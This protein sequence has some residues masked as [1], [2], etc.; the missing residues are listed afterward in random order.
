M[1]VLPF[2]EDTK[3]KE[4]AVLEELLRTWTHDHTV[5]AILRVILPTLAKLCERLFQDHLP[6]GRY[7]DVTSDVKKI[8]VGMPKHNKFSESVFG[9]LDQ[10]TR[11][12]PNITT[13]SAE[14]CDVFQQQDTGL[15]REKRCRKSE[16][17][18]ERSQP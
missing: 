16:V 9:F 18:P 13:L 7:V 11:A 3:V 1:F 4:G 10:L 14:A 6:G 5:Q 2:G 8:L 15:A 12:K 17:N